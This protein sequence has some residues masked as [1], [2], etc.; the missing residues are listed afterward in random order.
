MGQMT[1]ASGGVLKVNFHVACPTW[2]K[3]KKA[4]VYLNGVQVAEREITMATDR[5]FST[6]MIFEIPAP[7]HDAHLVCVAF[8]DGVKD[9]SW[10]TM[11]DFTLAVANPIF[12]DGDGDGKYSNPRET[13]LALL[14]KTNPLN[15]AAIEK[16]VA[17]VD[18]SIG[19]QL[20][21]ES[22]LRIATTDLSKF[23]EFLTSLAKTNSH[24][25][26]YRS[27]K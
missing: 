16:A 12:V 14:E 19:A 9:P 18:S 23:D 4:V 3:A 5:R 8:G 21:S 17:G 6:N 26:F 1:K 24:Y 11:A 2:I 7:Q 27:Q 22:K 20:L 13:A 10:K 15:I 25:E